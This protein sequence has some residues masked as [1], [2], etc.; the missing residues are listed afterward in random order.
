MSSWQPIAKTSDVPVGQGRT[1][2]ADGK[3]IAL[4][5]VDGE[6]R[7]IND[8]CPHMGASLSEGWVDEGAVTCPWHAWRFCLKN[9]SWLDAPKSKLSVETYAVRV[10][11]EDVLI[12][13]ESGGE[14]E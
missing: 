2:S 13:V 5:N 4:F 7:A 3:L 9:G 10:E 12:D 14:A 1:F 11:G 6:F 8:L